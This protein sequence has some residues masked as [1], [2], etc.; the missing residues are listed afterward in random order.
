LKGERIRQ[1]YEATYDS[2]DELYR[3]EQYEKYFS[4]LRV[5]PPRGAVLD[6]GCGTGLLIE[7]L[8][9]LKLVDGL[10]SLVCVDY[11][12]NML[13]LALWRARVACPDKCLAVYGNVE[14]LP[15]ESM[16][17]DVAYSFTVIDLVDDPLAA[18]SELARVSRGAVVVSV[19]RAHTTWR[20]LEKLGA[21]RIA[22]TSK[23]Y[24]YLVK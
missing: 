3:G 22:A 2:Y 15:F 17:F 11:S 21:T 18:I 12:M 4:A 16:S 10:S 24:I 20:L 6:A 19:M 7:F 13:R 5:V 8:A 14:S 23:D 1:R 9:S